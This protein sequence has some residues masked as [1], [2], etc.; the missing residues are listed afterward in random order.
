MPHTPDEVNV[1]AAHMLAELASRPSADRW[2][3][4]TEWAQTVEGD[5]QAWIVGSALVMALRVLDHLSVDPGLR[6]GIDQALAGGRDAVGP[7]PRGF[8]RPNDLD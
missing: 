1:I 2:N 7:L 8:K 4:V 6:Q 3:G 5:E